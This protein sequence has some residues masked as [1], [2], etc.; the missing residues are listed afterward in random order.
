MDE[1]SKSGI[2][3]VD[4][5][6]N[7]TSRDV[8]NRVS[9]LLKTKKV[10]HTGTLDPLATGVL[11]LTVGKCTKLSEFLTSK[12]KEYVAKFTLGFE[13]D[14]LDIT[15]TTTKTSSH[16][17]CEEDIKKCIL[18]FQGRYDQEV[19]LYSAIKKD[20]KR[21]YE[22][23]RNEEDIILPRREVDISRIEIISIE[24]NVVE[25]KTTVSKGTYIRSLIRDIGA[26]LQTYATMTELRRIA[27]GHISIDEAYT[28]EDIENGNFKLISPME[29]LSDI[30]TRELDE[31]DYKK[32]S[33][34]VAMSEDS[35]SEF[36]KFTY[37]KTLVA[38]YRKADE[39][40]RMYVKFTD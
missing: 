33:N 29:L 22:Y 9:R 17:A 15:G 38:L 27:Q 13:T 35:K 3:I 32:V 28:L 40:Y 31:E 30:E 25:I 5:P 4:K 37:Q 21:L 2:L 1:S 16:H 7:L 18:S 26:N 20:G 12:Y 24:E 8:V 34:G 10:G 14:T 6:K 11:I 23:A 36:I 19:P 39:H